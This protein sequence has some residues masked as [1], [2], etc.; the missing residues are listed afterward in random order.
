MKTK[1]FTFIIC[2]FLLVARCFAQTH[3]A[4]D[5][6][7]IPN[8]G[9]GYQFINDVN[10]VYQYY[11]KNQILNSAPYYITP[12]NSFPALLIFHCNEH[13]NVY[14][15]DD[16]DTG[17]DST[18]DDGFHYNTLIGK[19]RRATL[20]AAL[21][22]ITNTID[23]P[24]GV[25]LDL[26]VGKSYSPTHPA[27]LLPPNP[28]R[29]M[30]K[31][32]PIFDSASFNQPGGQG[33]YNG[34]MF[35]H[36]VSGIDPDANY[37][38][39]TICVNFDY[40]YLPN[41]GGGVSS[42]AHVPCNFWDDYTDSIIYSGIPIAGNSERFD[43]FT[44]LLH[45]MTHDLGFI[46]NIH[47]DPSSLLP[48]TP[49]NCFTK[50]DYTSLFYNSSASQVPQPAN[51][52]HLVTAPGGNPIIN[53][54]VS[55]PSSLRVDKIWLNALGK[56]YNHP[57]YASKYFNS[58]N[59]GNVDS[60]TNYLFLS[61]LDYHKYAFPEMAQYSPGFLPHY[62]MAPDFHLNEVV[63]FWS[64][65][66]LR[67]LEVLGY[68]LINPFPVLTLN[69]PPFTTAFATA[70]TQPITIVPFQTNNISFPE[71]ISPQYTLQNN[72]TPSFPVTSFLNITI[73]DAV[74]GL[75]DPENDT[76]TVD[77]ASVFGIRGVSSGGNN[78]NLLIID[79]TQTTFTYTPVPGYH[80]LAQFGFRATDGIE[81]G[82]LIIVTI[83]VLPGN[84]YTLNPG[85]EMIINGNFEDGTEVRQRL[86]SPGKYYTSLN[87]ECIDG[88]FYLGTHFCG[89]HPYSYLSNIL[90]SVAGEIIDKALTSV[91]DA[92]NQIPYPIFGHVS[93]THSIGQIGSNYN[94]A[95]LLPSPT[96][97]ER[98]HILRGDR[99]YS[100]L[101]NPVK[102]CHDYMFECDIN[103]TSTFLGLP[104]NFSP[105]K[106]TL[107]FIREPVDYNNPVVL[108]SIIIDITPPTN[109]DPDTQWIHIARP[110]KYCDTLTS[111]I[112]LIGPQ[113]TMNWVLQ[114]NTL[115]RVFIDNMS[116][117]ES[118]PPSII[119]TI[120]SKPYPTAGKDCSFTLNAHTNI[121]WCS[122]TIFKWYRLEAG[123][124]W[125]QLASTTDSSYSTTLTNLT[126]YSFCFVALDSCSTYKSDTITVHVI[127]NEVDISTNY[128]NEDCLGTGDGTLSLTN[129]SGGVSPYN[130]EWLENG[131][132]I[133]A[134]AGDTLINNVKAGNYKVIV[135]D[136]LGCVI[137]KEIP[138][139]TART[140]QWP[141]HPL[142][143]G[144]EEG[145]AM[146]LDNHGNVF[147]AGVFSLDILFDT[148][149]LTSTD[150]TDI[151]L[152]ELDHCGY[153]VWA[154]KIE[155]F[156][157]RVN[158]ICMDSYG[159]LILCGWFARDI[160]FPTGINFNS[161]GTTD[162]D[163][164]VA[165]YDASGNFIWARQIGGNLEDEATGVCVDIASNIYLTGS[166]HSDTLIFPTI[167][168]V[169]NSSATGTSD[170]WVGRCYAN[171]VFISAYSY[172][173]GLTDDFSRDIDYCAGCSTNY[174]LAITGN[175][176]TNGTSFMYFQTN[177]IN[178]NSPSTHMLT[179]GELNSIHLVHE[180][181]D[182]F[183]FIAGY[184]QA[185]ND[186]QA[187]VGKYN[188]LT[189]LIKWNSFSGSQGGTDYDEYTSS[190]YL[191]NNIYVSGN[192]SS[193]T[194]FFSILS[195]DFSFT[196]AGPPMIDNVIVRLD[197]AG[198]FT[199]ENNSSG[200]KSEFSNAM[201]VDAITNNI[202]Y[203][204]SFLEKTILGSNT[205]NA[206]YE[207]D[208]Y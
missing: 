51:L 96:I 189:G 118:A 101:I 21:D 78:H 108:Q 16:L 64:N 208:A 13:F 52:L 143:R 124:Q 139:T 132:P 204:G 28:V 158:D 32:S 109:Y 53:P 160:H 159:N 157:A 179:T 174:Q 81:T 206:M 54:L 131:T 107:E 90:G 25:V 148:I 34:Y 120:T 203:T 147:V 18:Q 188:A 114:F 59:C 40:Y 102:S 198:T 94:P 30:A 167:N 43:L 92:D 117:K 70:T 71:E 85:N 187:F 163:A 121:N 57:V 194:S 170:I 207:D 98:Y 36:I 183:V 184:F 141:Y 35:D 5:S 3:P 197:D 55:L 82:A 155:S 2:M 138:L 1:A 72:N 33:I 128:S 137:S 195:Q 95:P 89:G 12:Q 103:L 191:N 27:N 201:G 161:S 185:Y 42:P 68:T 84:T 116:L 24:N 74:L 100:L 111:T 190:E 77:T 23:I 56:P 166:Y 199:L 60:T 62:L 50:Y 8:C 202:Y 178:L 162:K 127:L 193:S 175:Y 133:T 144:K 73:T 153:P 44:V 126:D 104:A 87:N 63:Q 41:T 136:L 192:F 122:N 205:L 99:N 37:Y 10:T 75:H 146:T 172:A 151:F 150:G 26:H 177:N 110:V 130:I 88:E 38:D 69:N 14:F 171:G 106:M 123:G 115:Q 196:N 186:K 9:T 20:C 31:A 149:L 15:E 7:I 65:A 105:R 142:G 181:N 156:S 134:W 45:Q 19:V 66:E 129:I 93:N 97:N 119:A 86:V 58:S 67:E 165:K 176:F 47:E 169:F 39:A 76:I 79:A 145:T 11:C 83:E 80:G 17:I 22:L 112:R 125:N 135:T 46:S 200:T 154:I 91:Y 168:P 173:I 48:A 49:F 4:N 113:P 182:D 180:G 61:H 152:A 6:L 164:F 29:W 140:D